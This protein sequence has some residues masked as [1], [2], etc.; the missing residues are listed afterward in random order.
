MGVG[1][2]ECGGEAVHL[3][4]KN[5]SAGWHLNGGHAYTSGPLQ[6]RSLPLCSGLFPYRKG[7]PTTP[8]TSHPSP[9][10]FKNP[11]SAT[12]S[13]QDK[14]AALAWHTRPFT[15]GLHP[16]LSSPFSSNCSSDALWTSPPKQATLMH[17]SLCPWAKPFPLSGEPGSPCISLQPYFQVAMANSISQGNLPQLSRQEEV[18]LGCPG[19]PVYATKLVMFPVLSDSVPSKRPHPV[20]W[21]HVL[22]FIA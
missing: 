16:A 6:S 15:F 11:S 3:S 2:G 22:L 20:T 19:Y 21:P 9:N 8:V 17:L 18:L 14:A 12:F 4:L 7:G 10:P 5:L 13:A 1:V